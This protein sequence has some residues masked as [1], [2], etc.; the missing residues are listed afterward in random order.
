MRALLHQA[1][2]AG[3][4]PEFIAA[5]TDDEALNL[6]HDWSLWARPSQLTPEGLWDVWLILAG[7]GFGKTRT[8]AEF[9]RDEVQSGRAMRIHLVAATAQDAR[10]V[11]VEGES[12]LLAISHPKWTP[13]Y[14]PSRRLV[15]WPN[16]A[17]AKL[18]SAEKPNRLRGPQCDLAWADEIA[19]WQRMRE[20]W[21]NLRFGLRLGPHPRVV[22]TTTGKPRRLLH[23]LVTEPGSHVTRGSLYEN[24]KNLA[25]S[26]IRT[27]L[28]KYEGTR[29]GRQEIGGELLM[30]VPG[31]LWNRELLEA[32]RVKECPPLERIVVAIDPAVTVSTSSNETGIIVAGVARGPDRTPHGYVVRDLSG[33]WNANQWAR[34]AVTAYRELKADRIIGEVNNGGDLIEEQLKVVD[35]NV[36]YRAVHATRGKR[37][38]AEPVAA[39]SEQGRLHLVGVFP[40]LEDQMCSFNPNEQGDDDNDDQEAPPARDETGALVG[41]T[42]TGGSPDRVDALVWAMFDLIIDRGEAQTYDPK[43]WAVAQIGGKGSR[44]G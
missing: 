22:V 30:D 5:L 29:L 20:T 42:F 43:E 33:F 25:P 9:V 21:D 14:Q 34:K 17:M 18:F 32:G 16:G 3:K 8:G 13:V 40:E 12:G 2:A 10:D 36:P 27:I 7:R 28:R 44:K 26:F 23:E 37:K 39:L 38:R 1:K 41:P 4:L 35:R 6:L 19:A 24:Q 31:A 11:M 15:T